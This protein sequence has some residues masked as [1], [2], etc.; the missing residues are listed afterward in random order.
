MSSPSQA[1]LAWPQKAQPR[2]LAQ[3]PQGRVGTRM[4]SRLI[5]LPSSEMQYLWISHSMMLVPAKHRL[6]GGG[7]GQAYN[8]PHTS[9]PPGPP[10]SPVTAWGTTVMRSRWLSIFTPWSGSCML[11]TTRSI[12]AKRAM[13][14]CPRRPPLTPDPDSKDLAPTPGSVCAEIKPHR[15][16]DFRLCSQK[17]RGGG[18]GRHPPQRRGSLPPLPAPHGARAPKPAS[19]LA[20]SRKV[21]NIVRPQHPLLSC[22]SQPQ[23]RKILGTA[24]P[25]TPHPP[26]SGAAFA[27]EGARRGARGPRPWLLGEAGVAG[28]LASEPSCPA[29]R[30][31]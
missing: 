31:S 5:A 28:L 1:D 22:P 26:C 27:H 15:W 3:G 13:R 19:I 30:L 9:S 4:G 24:G 17:G 8:P 18:K 12:W 23:G 7:R 2:L 20:H 11:T 10:A 14:G 21:H 29:P 6:S 16:W 25:P